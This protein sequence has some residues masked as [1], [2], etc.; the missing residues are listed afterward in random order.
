MWCLVGV[1]YSTGETDVEKGFNG[2]LKML[3]TSSFGSLHLGAW[4]ETL[5]PALDSF[6][7]AETKQF[8]VST[9]SPRSL[10]PITECQSRDPHR[11]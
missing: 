10:K 9:T 11:Q 4:T 6:L 7:C 8:Q 5:I 1:I 2:R 3:R